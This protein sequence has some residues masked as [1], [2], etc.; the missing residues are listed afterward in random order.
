MKKI[1]NGK[2]KLLEIS[3]LLLACYPLLKF[4]ISSFL[5]IVFCVLALINSIKERRFYFTIRNTKRFLLF[6]FYFF[7]LIISILYSED[8]NKAVN[9]ILQLLP[10]LLVPFVIIFFNPIFTERL[11][12]RA[13]SLFLFCNVVYVIILIGVY[14][15]NT[16][17]GMLYGN[18][19]S[20]IPR[21]DKI[22]FILNSVIRGDLLFVHKAYFSMGFVFI[23]ILALQRSNVHF[24][25]NFRKS[26][27]YFGVFVVFSIFVVYAYSFPNIIALLACILLFIL[28]QHKA[29]TLAIRRLIVPY[30]IVILLGVLAILLGSKDLDIKRGISFV[31]SV[32]YQKDVEGNDPRIEI[33]R[34]YG[35]IMKKASLSEV[36]F[37]FGVGDEQ[38]LLHKEVGNRLFFNKNKNLLSFNEEFNNS[39]WFRNHVGVKSNQAIAPNGKRTAD[40]LE[41]LHNDQDVSHNISTELF[42]EDNVMY[43]F[44]VFAK[45][46]DASKLVLRLGEMENRAYFDLDVGQLIGKYEGVKQASIEALG[47]QWY[48]CSISVTGE[49]NALV[50]LGILSGNATYHHQGASRGLFLW[51]A[52]VERRRSTSNYIKNGSELMNYMY[53]ENLNTHNNYLFFLLTGGILCLSAFLGSLLFLFRESF[54][55]KNILQVSFCIIITLNFLTENIFSRHWGLMFVSVLALILFTSSKL[56]SNAKESL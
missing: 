16:N 52:Q 26:Y 54:K 51:G 32:L 27:L 18:E 50:I 4:N 43:S 37:G 9:R 55:N 42:L 39:Y 31:N 44:S 21:Y 49:G 5:L 35:S 41:E 3:F 40:F 38:N 25:K 29:N 53:K 13:L 19:S 23:S 22:Q 11:K 17:S 47:N 6:T 24:I 56:K 12:S 14:L 46:L 45:A 8:D 34:T 30:A 2:V 28:F 33:Y 36:I 10:L 1:L 48:R 20:I 15:A 7:L